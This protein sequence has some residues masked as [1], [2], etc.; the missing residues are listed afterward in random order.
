M[1]RHEKRTFGQIL[2]IGSSES[3]VTVLIKDASEDILWCTGTATPSATTGFAKGCI[4]IRSDTG[5]G[6]VN[7]GTTTSCSFVA[8][9]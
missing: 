2:L 3:A 1:A 7:T 8:L 9:G 4:L 6:Y 5:A